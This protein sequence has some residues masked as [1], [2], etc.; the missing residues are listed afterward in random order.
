MLLVAAVELKW[1]ILFYL[2]PTS[3]YFEYLCY[4]ISERHYL[5]QVN[6][7]CPSQWRESLFNSFAQSEEDSAAPA[8]THFS[9]S[10]LSRS[11]VLVFLP[12]HHSLLFSLKQKNNKKGRIKGRSR[13]I[14]KRIISSKVW[15]DPLESVHNPVAPMPKSYCSFQNLL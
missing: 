9:F 5:T 6:Q 3:F 12:Q 13:Q 4:N 8:L 15:W 14:W 1:H 2:K 11:W 7:I 10:L